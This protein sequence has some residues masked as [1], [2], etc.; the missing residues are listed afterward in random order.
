MKWSKILLIILVL[1]LVVGFGFLGMMLNEVR[2]G[3]SARDNPTRLEEAIANTMRGWA[4]PRRARSMTNPVT[5]TPQVMTEAR[6]HYADHCAVCHAND[7]SGDTEMGRGLYPKPPDMRKQTQSM[8]D[9]EIYYTIENGVR[10]T[11]MPAWG[12]PA[13]DHDHAN[14]NDSWALVYFIRHLPQ[15][16]AGELRDMQNYNPKSPAEMQED[17]QE[18][19]FL[20]E[21]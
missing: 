14:D 4:M 2:A 9:G 5:L 1:V 21:K 12:A 18:E 7:G 11:G 10:L 8:S 13:A 20:N 15:L 19:N 3:V 16:T 17:K 6:R